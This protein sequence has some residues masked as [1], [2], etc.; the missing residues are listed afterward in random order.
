[1]KF[2]IQCQQVVQSHGITLNVLHSASAILQADQ[3]DPNLD[4]LSALL[5]LRGTRCPY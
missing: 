1:M 4:H 5:F 3:I 2:D